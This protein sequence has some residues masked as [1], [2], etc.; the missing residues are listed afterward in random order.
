[1]RRFGTCITLSILFTVMGGFIRSAQS[2]T[3]QVIHSFNGVDGQNPY[4]G[5]TIDRGGNLYGTTFQGGADGAGTVFKLAPRG[6]GWIF[7]PLHSFSRSDGASPEGRVVFGPDGTLYGTTTFGGLDGCPSGCGTVF[8]LRPPATACKTGLCPWT[9]TV[10]HRFTGGFDGSYPVSG[11]L[12]FDD[13][14]DIYGT[15]STG[16]RGYG[17]VFELTP[18]GTESVLY[19]FLGG[20][21]AGPAS[22][23]I[24]DN[25]GNLYGTTTNQGGALYQLMPS[26]VGWAENTLF[27]FENNGNG[28]YPYGGLIFDHSGNI[29]GTTY[30]GGIN[31]GGTAFEATS[32]NGMWTLNVIYSFRGFPLCDGPSASL[33]MDVAGNLYGTTVCGPQGYGSVFKLTPSAGG[34]TYTDLH[35]FTGNSDGAYPY[36]NVVLDT[37]GNLY[38]TASAGG[39]YGGDCV[40]SMGCGVVWEITP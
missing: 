36:S 39:L 7:N 16:G 1:M 4:A 29:Y 17:V 6:S 11:D 20:L 10:L 14:G 3:F 23:V 21:V 30:S 19:A 5:L 26:G 27:T 18:S 28:W 32:S 2:Q 40:G 25:A 15:T 24:L 31:H 12:V 22:G 35:D 9:K 34:W 8:N 38:G 37:S 13:T 33:V